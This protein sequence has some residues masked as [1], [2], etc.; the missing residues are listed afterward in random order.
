MPTPA[1]IAVAAAILAALVAFI[2]GIR[3]ADT[4]QHCEQ[5]ITTGGK[6][7]AVVCTRW[8]DQ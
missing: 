3:H 6:G 8:S 5:W 1:R 2:L 7:S 4:G